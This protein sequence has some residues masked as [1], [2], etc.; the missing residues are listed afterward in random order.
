MKGKIALAIGVLAIIVSAVAFVVVF[1]ST[2]SG[3]EL[4]F[5]TYDDP[6]AYKIGGLY[7]DARWCSEN[8]SRWDGA[9][10]EWAQGPF[11]DCCQYIITRVVYEG[12]TPRIDGGT[13]ACYAV[14]GAKRKAE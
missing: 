5:R 14:Y 12:E 9:T 1:H 10:G 11:D 13:S 3:D 4:L 6:K 8:V 2:L 7:P